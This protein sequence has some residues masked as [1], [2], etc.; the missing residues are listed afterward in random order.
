MAMK[1]TPKPSFSVA[2]IKKFRTIK[3][4]SELLALPPAQQKKFMDW[5]SQRSLATTKRAMQKKGMA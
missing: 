4:G 1:P 5:Q 3:K 2:E